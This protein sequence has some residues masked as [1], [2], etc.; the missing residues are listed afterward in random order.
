MDE[1]GTKAAQAG[2]KTTLPDKTGERD[3]MTFG[4]ARLRTI[5]I[6]NVNI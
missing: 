2:T 5:H 6:D 3:M 4:S 1:A